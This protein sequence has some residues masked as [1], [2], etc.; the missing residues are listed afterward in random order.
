MGDVRHNDSIY[1]TVILQYNKCEDMTRDVRHNDS[2]YNTVI[3]QYNKCEDMTKDVTG[4]MSL[5]M[6][7]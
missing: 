6:S 4:K 3:L 5:A 1:N 7:H 2:I